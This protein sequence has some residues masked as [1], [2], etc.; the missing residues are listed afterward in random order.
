MGAAIIHPA[1]AVII[2]FIVRAESAEPNAVG[3]LLSG[4]SPRYPR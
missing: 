2:W 3:T 1:T 4:K